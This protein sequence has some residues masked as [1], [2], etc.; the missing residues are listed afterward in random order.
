MRKV[1][2]FSLLAWG[3][4]FSAMAL[5]V[6]EGKAALVEAV[7][8]KVTADEGKGYKKLKLG[9][10]LA[11]GSSIRTG[12]NGR[13]SLRLPDGSMARI[14]SNT[15][16]T[17]KAPTERKG[18][19]TRLLKGTV[20]F[21][22]AKQTA[23]NSFETE[24]P[25]AVA[26]VKGT[27][28]EYSTDGTVTTAK[29]FSSG[30]PV[31]LLFTDTKSGKETELK[32]GEKLTFDGDSFK[33]ETLE[34]KD[35]EDSDKNYEGLPEAKIEG[36]EEAK[37]G[38]GGTQGA[39]GGQSTQ[40]TQGGEGTTN[41]GTT[42]EATDEG[43]DKATDEA[44]Q[45]ATADL[46]LDGFLERDE[47][48]GDI[49]AGKIVY[50]RFGERVQVSHFI[51]RPQDNQVTVASFSLRDSGPNAG[52][53][54]AI[55]SSTFNKSLPDDW[56]SVF[57][58]SLVD[59]AN[60]DASGYPVY[61]RTVEDFLAANPAG[62]TVHIA[63]TFQIPRWEGDVN[64]NITGPLFQAYNQ[65]LYV[66]GIQNL[67]LSWG[68]DGT[69]GTTPD[70]L[71][72]DMGFFGGIQPIMGTWTSTATPFEGGWNFALTGYLGDPLL[73]QDMHF[74]DDQGNVLEHPG[75]DTLNQPF[76]NVFRGFD[77]NVELAFHSPLFNG[78][79]IDLIM[80]PGFFDLYDMLMLPAVSYCGSC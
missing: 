54:S 64:G 68:A 38:E 42:D 49:A 39:Q 19:F 79:S 24:V 25:S 53:S 7:V 26:A 78:R 70:P 28:P 62:D 34:V 65:Q 20:R 61:F 5:P 40:S 22:V 27:D 31:A 30:N 16:M 12:A 4:S 10:D 51:T 76:P 74:I 23:G 11:P 66:N 35:R 59:S 46:Y 9:Q 72:I 17:L 8:G 6:P 77:A 45:E 43:L 55:E 14:A 56:G 21:L 63:T 41:G 69:Y 75:F 2:L 57:R 71:V 32:A 15:E 36:G 44:M 50:D 73:S 48:T 52:V 13:V 3:L 67:N 80:L 47:R 60:L 1:I 58:R 29:V 18:I 37:G 33:L